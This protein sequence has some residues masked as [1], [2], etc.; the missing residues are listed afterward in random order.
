VNGCRLSALPVLLG[1]G[2]AAMVT[3]V[4]VG[5]EAESTDHMARADVEKIETLL[6]DS[7]RSI[8]RIHDYRGVLYKKELFGDALIEQRIAFKFSRPFQVY[9]RYIEPNP[10]R[11]VI[12]VRGRNKNRLKAHRG[13]GVDITVNLNPRS[14]WAMAEGHHPVTEFGIEHML[15]L[16][17]RDVRK[18][19]RRGD[20]G[21]SIADGGVVNGEPT[22]RIELR[23]PPDGRKVTARR[24]ETLWGLAARAGQDMYVVLHHNESIDS[25]RDIRAGQ[26]VFVPSYYASRAQY[27]FSKQTSLLIKLVIWDHNGALYEIYEYPELVLNP[28][29]EALDFDYRNEAYDF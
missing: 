18:A 29:F 3:G 9:L 14:R 5:A 24:D 12:Y 20:S 17:A 27:F 11:E 28:G 15:E 7:F 21:L 16:A 26:E 6:K 8:G 13:S 22:W 4:A 25:P 1:L 2:C 10:G 23:N 19:L